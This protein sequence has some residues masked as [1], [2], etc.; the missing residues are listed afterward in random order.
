[1][2]I[3]SLFLSIGLTSGEIIHRGGPDIDKCRAG[4]ETPDAIM[5]GV[6]E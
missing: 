3:Y 1:M 5:T 6:L 2:K 4:E